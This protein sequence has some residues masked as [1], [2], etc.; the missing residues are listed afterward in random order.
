MAIVLPTIVFRLTSPVLGLL[1]VF[2]TKSAYERWRN[3]RFGWE[4]IQTHSTNLVRQ[5]MAY[6]AD[7]EKE[8]CVRRVIA[9]ALTLKGHFRAGTAERDKLHRELAAVLGAGEAARLMEAGERPAQALSDVSR[10]VRRSVTVDGSTR[11]RFDVHLDEIARALVACEGIRSTPA[12]LIYTRH[13]AR[14]L[15]IWTLLLPFALVAE[16]GGRS[17]LIPTCALVSLLLFGVEELGLHI[18]EPFSILPLEHLAD[19]VA[20]SARQMLAYE[21][22]SPGDPAVGPDAAP[23]LP[24]QAP[25]APASPAAATRL[26]SVTV[27]VDNTTDAVVVPHFMVTIGNSH[28][29]GFWHTA[30]GRP[31][32]LAPHATSVV[33]LRPP[34]ATAAPARGTYWLVQAYTSSPEAL[35]ASPLQH[36]T[37]GPVR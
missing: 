3:A 12:P 25:P 7:D 16:F 5:G 37:S 31:V 13:T 18:D 4:Q 21:R 15:G 23:I 35:S 2:R 36:W 1:L 8:E 11:A 29:S 6:L 22:S 28:P 24:P 17:A 14:F 10:V 34:G 27:D 32:V 20:R 19:R 33:T 9:L 30:D 26:D